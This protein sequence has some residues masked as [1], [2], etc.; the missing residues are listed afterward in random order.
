MQTT[1]FIKMFKKQYGIPPIAYFNRLKIY[2]AMSLLLS[3]DLSV[4]AIA[5]NVGINDPSYFARMF[6]E[7]ANITPTRYRLEFKHK[8]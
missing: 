5:Q 1:Y 4:D 2:K 7:H 3:T 6:R 8:L